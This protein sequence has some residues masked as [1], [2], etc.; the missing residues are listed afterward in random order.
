MAKYRINMDNFTEHFG[1]FDFKASV[2][3]IADDDAVSLRQM[4]RI[5]ELGDFK[6][7]R[8]PDEPEP[9]P[10]SELTSDITVET[11]NAEETEYQ[12][13]YNGQERG[14]DVGKD[15]K[16][17]KTNRPRNRGRSRPRKQGSNS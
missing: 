2:C 14:G 12:P 10:E 8:I 3:E 1:G 17:R 13:Q 7:T 16:K 5:N 6:I 4:D 15:D 9:E 11:D